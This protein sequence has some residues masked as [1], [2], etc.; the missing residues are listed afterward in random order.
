MG[1][2]QKFGLGRSEFR[3]RWGHV[4]TWLRSVTDVCL[5]YS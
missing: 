3:R 1:C 2:T 4:G 5:C